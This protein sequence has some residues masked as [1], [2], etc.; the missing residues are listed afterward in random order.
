MIR[1]AH[2]GNY[3]GRNI[4]RENHPF[5]IY[6]AWHK[7]F[8]VEMDVW[9]ENEKFYLG[10]DK[11]MHFV[12]L[13]FLENDMFWVHAKNIA[14]LKQLWRNPKVNVFWH[15]KD[16][17]TFTSQGFKWANAGMMTFDGIAVMPEYSIPLLS[18][19]KNTHY[20][21]LGICSDDFGLIGL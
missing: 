4:D 10:H 21:P 15:E 2:R 12:S 18:A 16:D 3:A 11:P 19:I 7:G 1:I 17:Y 20:K 6:E 5:Y 14:A 8:D 13:E 9:Y